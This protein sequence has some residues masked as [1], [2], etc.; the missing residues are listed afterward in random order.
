YLGRAGAGGRAL[1]AV[2]GMGSSEFAE[3]IF[4]LTASGKK[5]TVTEVVG[6]WDDGVAQ[7]ATADAIATNGQFDGITAQGGDTGVVKAMIDAKH[8]FVPFGG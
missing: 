7:K 4:R 5:F 3:A 1:H 8:T 6:K 2:G